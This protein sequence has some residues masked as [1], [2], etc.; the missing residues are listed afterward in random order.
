[1]NHITFILFPKFFS[2]VSS[3]FIYKHNNIGIN[4]VTCNCIKG[5]LDV[6]IS[7]TLYSV[8]LELE[9]CLELIY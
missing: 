8:C 3:V 2:H 5:K 1:M 9:N 7:N 6:D 4:N